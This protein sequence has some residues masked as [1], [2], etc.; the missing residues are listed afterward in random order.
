MAVTVVI[1]SIISFIIIQLPPG[2]YLSL[3]EGQ[4]RDERMTQ[5]QIQ[6]VLK[7]VEERFG[8]GEPKYVQYWR[9]VSGILRGDMGY[10]MTQMKSVNELLS[11]RLIL[12]MAISVGTLL[13]TL[14]VSVP[15]G[16]YS[17]VRQYSPG[18][19]ILTVIGFIG[20]A[21][22]NFLLALILLF[23]AVVFFGASSV[24]GLF[25]PQYVLAPWSLARVLDLLKHLWVPVI[26]VGT[27]GTA[28]TIR[29]MRARMLDNLGEPY[30]RTARMKGIGE[31]RVIFKH[32]LRVAINPII[33][34]LG[35]SLPA[36]ISGATITSIVLALP[37]TGPLLLNA[38]LGEDMYLA[39]TILLILTVALV[40]GNFLADL[41]LA[42]VDPRIRLE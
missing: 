30:I 34:S 38:L 7:A 6:G 17:A 5:D 22:P 40:V 15:I 4:L 41:A 18:D 2:D 13:F 27:S 33:T 16:I 9:W 35:M 8:L 36:I 29:V 28:A 26:V 42:W 14:V 25:S 24:G 1:V 20:L 37:T 11:E 39:S 32:A 3:L 31:S 10:S 19:Y 23:V 21:T 12:T